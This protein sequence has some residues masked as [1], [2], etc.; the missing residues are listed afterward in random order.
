MTATATA[1]LVLA[2]ALGVAANAATGDA[3][4]PGP[5]DLLRQHAWPAVGLLVT[6]SLVIFIAR[7]WK[8]DDLQAWR[9]DPPP[10]PIALVPEWF[11]ARPETQQAV[12]AV[13]RVDDD[14]TVGI[15]TSLWGAGGFGKT[16]LA[17]AVC[18]HRQ[19]RRSFRKRIYTV[20]I[21]R[22]VRGRA[23]IAAKV[24]EV[25]RFITGDTTE[26]G[27]DPQLAGQHLGR[28]LDERPRTLLVL[29]DVWEEE[30]LAP[31]LHGGR[32]CVRLI[33]TRN[34]V[35]L[36]AGA[37]PIQVDEM[38]PAQARVLLTW[39]LRPISEELLNELLQATGR[40][41]LLLR[42]TNR[43]IAEQTATGADPA[44]A[45]S[46]VLQQLRAAGPAAVDDP[47]RGW[48]LGDPR[49]R[50][51]AVRA[52][53]EA[54]TL[55]LPPG[56]ADRFAE[57]AVFAE[58]EVIPITL[59]AVLWGA[60]AGIT[61]AQ[62]RA[63]CRN[64]ERLSLITIVADYGGRINLHDVIRD[65]LRADLG[66]TALIA[67]NGRFVDA[68]AA[69]LPS[70]A[71]LAATAPDPEHAWWT[72][73]DGYL[74][75]HLIEHITEAGRVPYAEAVAGDLRWVEARLYQRGP[76]APWNDL[77]R[78][79]T[80][81]GRSLAH[82]LA[83]AAHLLAPTNPPRALA[84]VLYNR[85]QHHPLW[86]DQVAARQ[87]DPDQ[88]P[89][90]A[91]RM[92]PPD[93][94]DPAMQ[95]TLTG[96]INPVSAVYIS[97][98]GASIVSA[99]GEVAIWDAATGTC[100]KMFARR[101]R[102][103]MAV[104]PDGTWL[105]TGGD[106]YTLHIWDRATATC[107]ATL[108]GHTNSV[109]SV[110]ISPDGT[111]L[112]TASD[113]RAVRIWDRAT[114]T[115]TATLTGHTDS[116][117][118]VVVSPDGAWLATASA[119][120]TVRIWDRATATCTATLTG[121]TN[122][123]RSVAISPDGTWLATGCGDGVVRIWDRGTATC[124]ANLLGHT[125]AV[126]SVAISPDGTWLATGCGDGPVR[127]WDPAAGSA[128]AA[129]GLIDWVPSLAISVDNT[130]YVSGSYEGT[131]RIWDHTTGICT[132]RLA[133]H[134][135][136]VLSVAIAP[137]GTWLAT[138]SRDKTV[139]VWDRA[140]G[141]CTA[142]LTSHAGEVRSVAIAPDGTW[143]ATGCGDATVRVWDHAAGACTAVLT[144]HELPVRVVAIA[145]DGTWLA[146]GGYDG[147]VRVWRVRDACTVAVARADGALQTCLWGSDS[148]GLA[149]GGDRGVYLFQLR[150]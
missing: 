66:E 141:T 93:Q 17:T 135:R 32:L 4:W 70:A 96:H 50:S 123:V 118:R 47:V 145:P 49:E 63:L 138:G 29:D 83:Q 106:G 131:V 27:D 108:T 92:P 113:D 121:H 99:A 140:T 105:A 142:T 30:Q 122:V 42:L 5:L 69:T 48:N 125:N 111:W 45:A 94:P 39:Q 1:E 13:C 76:T 127:I 22:D 130:F 55:L 3:Q 54:A 144:G 68:V 132:A 91:A 79:D 129:L 81:H 85:L 57:L 137:D 53:I 97:P 37:V 20:T 33:T 110:A 126:M 148:H 78:I 117:Y 25:T 18:S 26:Y 90:L 74:L 77:T 24:A 84:G 71:P 139:R 95:R 124:T 87:S 7:T 82:S 23:A 150:T 100:T 41:A 36:P 147:M 102:G 15:T 52:T 103:T 12:Q 67:L 9:N 35:L 21:G 64:L 101:A 31:F 62:T 88:L 8:P 133:G 120:C 2:A 56:G 109:R 43:L 104:S 38:S 40:W 10:P 86:G 46:T 16:T 146:S 143:L 119:D 59:V 134:T 72:L 51:L 6:L 89:L 98:D 58:D 11:V 128:A 60:T 107:T 19:V 112:A 136:P 116:V 149:V 28:L 34:P 115:C 65:Y 44:D 114:A 73:S 14:A 75:D 61:E 80:P